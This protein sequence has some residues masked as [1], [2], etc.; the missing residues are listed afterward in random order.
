MTRR[1]AGKVL[2]PCAPSPFNNAPLLLTTPLLH[3]VTI[4]I[5]MAVVV[6]IIQGAE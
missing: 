5:I 6:F 4:Y 1:P 2:Y 3:L